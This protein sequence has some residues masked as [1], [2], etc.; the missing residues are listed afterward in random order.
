MKYVHLFCVAAL[1]IKMKCDQLLV[2]NWED[3]LL[4]NRTIGCTAVCM[5]DNPAYVSNRCCQ[6]SSITNFRH[7]FIGF[8]S[9]SSK[10][11][12]KPDGALEADDRNEKQRDD[13]ID[14]LR[15]RCHCDCGGEQR[16][17]QIQ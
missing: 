10:L 14:M 5:Q 11:H 4:L 1:F 3:D 8:E 12:R 7:F 15:C 2:E 9:M 6:F 17:T 16:E 13:S